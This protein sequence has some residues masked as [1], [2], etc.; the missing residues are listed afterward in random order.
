MSIRLEEKESSNRFPSIVFRLGDS[1]R[2]PL[3]S[4]LNHPWLTAINEGIARV[5]PSAV[6]LRVR[7]NQD[8]GYGLNTV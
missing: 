8:G 3:P 5:R 6:D 4:Q 1:S 7:E 2:F